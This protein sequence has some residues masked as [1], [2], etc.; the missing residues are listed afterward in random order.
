MK[1][2]IQLLGIFALLLLVFTIGV[3]GTFDGYYGFY[4]ENKPYEKPFVYKASENII[5]SQAVSMFASY[6][7]FDTG[8]GFYAPNVAS[9]FVLT[10]EL[11]DKNGNTIDEKAMPS[12][13]KKESIVRYTT[14]FNLFLDKISGEK[15]K[16]DN[17]YYQYLDLI[18]KEIA[19]SVMKKN[20]NASQVT[21]RLYLYDYPSITDYKKGKNK[22]DLILVN[23]FKY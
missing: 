9:D 20:A 3:K 12:F 7:G 18:I 5:Q 22:E 14:I 11:K 21:A 1:K 23:E 16:F 10:F 4:Y 2:K 17:K 8:Y 6:T 15:N 13:Q 19:L